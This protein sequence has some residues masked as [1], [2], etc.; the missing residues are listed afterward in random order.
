[1][2]ASTVATFAEHP[3]PTLLRLGVPVTINTDDFTIS[4]ITLS[5]EY[6]NCF[7]GLG[8]TLPE[9]WVCNLHALDAAFVDEPTRR[10]LRDEF[11]HWAAPIPELSART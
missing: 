11:R 5:E 3:L 10:T 8:I 4:D 9:L 7:A 2:Q 6:L 1:M